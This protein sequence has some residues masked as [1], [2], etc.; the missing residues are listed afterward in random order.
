M[1][2]KLHLLLATGALVASSNANA[3]TIVGLCNTGQNQTCTGLRSGN[4]VDFN[5]TVTPS[6]NGSGNGFNPANVNSSWLGANTT[7]RWITPTNNGTATIAAGTF[8]YSLVFAIASG[9]NPATASFSG[10]FAV[11]NTVDAIRLNG[12]LISGSGGT[13]TG[14]SNFFAN[15][16]FVNGSNTLTFTVRNLTGGGANPSGLRVEFL[17]SNVAAVPE[18]ATWMMMLFGFGL[19]GGLLR[20]RSAGLKARRLTAA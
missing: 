11:D 5:W 4:G 18:P 1:I 12:N 14:W 9:F 7:S 13:F 15:N 6:Q 2:K 17:Q 8:Q 19:I 10:R 20:R 3:T 16:G